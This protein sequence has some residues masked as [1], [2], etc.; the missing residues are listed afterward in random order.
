MNLS[1]FLIATALI[2]L[3]LSIF[4]LYAQSFFRREGS[5]MRRVIPFEPRTPVPWNGLEVFLFFIA[6]ILLVSV[7]ADVCEHLQFGSQIQERTLE[8]EQ[9]AELQKGHALVQFIACGRD[10]PRVFLVVFLAAVIII[11]IGE[12]FLFRLL[13]QGWLEKLEGSLRKVLR[14]F[15]GLF[16][17][18]CSSVIFAAIHWRSTT[19]VRPFQELF[20]GFLAMTL[21]WT[22]M[23]VVVTAYLLFVRSA[24]LRDLGIDHRKIFG[25]CLLGLGAVCFLAPPIYLLNGGLLLLYG[26]TNYTLDP[27]PLFF[28]AVGLG[29]LY[30]RTRRILPC[31]VLHGV[32][33]GISVG[34]AY[35]SAYTF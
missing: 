8:P 24:T 30:Y 9:I 35:L 19:E 25:D 4:F 26:D 28:F 7:S 12:E 32:F 18:L 27:I 2:G 15:R 29:V 10:D 13:L 33:N 11:P 17:V 21:G 23:I 1:H 31:I 14:L 16:A 22:A 34:G 3:A 5:F 20:D 6:W